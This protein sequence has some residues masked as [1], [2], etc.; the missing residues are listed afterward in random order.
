MWHRV[1][2]FRTIWSSF[3]VHDYSMTQS[4]FNFA[5][6]FYEVLLLLLLRQAVLFMFFMFFQSLEHEECL[7]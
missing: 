3:N 7:I 4:R 1:L 5:G 6:K 2:G